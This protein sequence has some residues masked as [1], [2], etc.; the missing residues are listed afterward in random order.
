MPQINQGPGIPEHRVHCRQA[1]FGDI[2]IRLR[3]LVGFAGVHVGA[4]AGRVGPHNPE[5]TTA[6]Q[7]FMGYTGRDNDDIAPAH[8]EFRPCGT[9]QLNPRFAAVNPECLMGRAVI[10]VIAENTVTP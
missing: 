4:L 2:A 7:I 5:I 3:A 6:A 8:L 9:A 1:N 10:M